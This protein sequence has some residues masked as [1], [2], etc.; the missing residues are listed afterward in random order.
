[1]FRRRKNILLIKFIIIKL[2]I[3]AY[4]ISLAVTFGVSVDFLSFPYLNDLVQEV[5]KIFSFSL[6]L[7]FVF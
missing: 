3:W 1:M 2:I 4:P 7:N 6:G 5:Y